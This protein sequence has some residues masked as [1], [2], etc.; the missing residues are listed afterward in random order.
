VWTCEYTS[1]NLTYL[2]GLCCVKNN[3][4]DV[5]ALGVTP[6]FIVEEL[7]AFFGSLEDHNGALDAEVNLVRDT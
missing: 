1:A 3:T 6:A 5:H 7:L 2:E 4:F